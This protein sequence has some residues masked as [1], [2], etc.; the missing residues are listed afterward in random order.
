MKAEHV[1][2]GIPVSD[3]PAARAWYERLLGRPPD[4]LPHES[5]AAWQLN[6]GGWIYVVADA[7]RAGR[8]LVTFL[9]DDIAA[10]P[11]EADRSIPGM[12]R[13]DIVD[14][15]GNKI[16]VAQQAAQPPEELTT[17]RRGGG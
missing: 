8:A 6:E 11:V 9:V 12:L 1:F 4:L 13:G 5:E 10:W 14:P 17:R 15:D 7:E 16:Q 3:Y 2:A